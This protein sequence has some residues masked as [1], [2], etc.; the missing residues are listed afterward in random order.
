MFTDEKY[1]NLGLPQQESFTEDVLQQITHRW[2]YYPK[3]STE[4]AYRKGLF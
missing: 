2:Q 1:Y 4:E 3:G